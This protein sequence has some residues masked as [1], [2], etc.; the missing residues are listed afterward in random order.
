MSEEIKSEEVKNEES[1]EA[2]REE[3]KME[4]PAVET[5]VE[6]VTPVRAQAPEAT[7]EAPAAAASPVAHVPSTG[8][9]R[10]GD[11]ASGDDQRR[12]MGPRA[13]RF[14]RKGCRFCQNKS[15]VVDY[16][17]VEILERF[18]TDRGKILPRRITG[19]CAKHQRSIALAIKR[20]RI[21]ALLPFIVQ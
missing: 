6:I 14:K 21:V 9:G 8:G 1:V 3:V 5:S 4:A 11:S 10:R 16:K 2:P 7:D 13:P 15:L 19:T 12:P 17:N 20:A 18:I